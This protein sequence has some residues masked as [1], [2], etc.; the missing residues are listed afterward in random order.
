MIGLPVRGVITLR[1][2]GGRHEPEFMSLLGQWP[3]GGVICPSLAAKKRRAVF[4]LID[5][6]EL[7]VTSQRCAGLVAIDV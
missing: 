2:N 3:G 4:P 7:P 5:G 6:Y 1:I